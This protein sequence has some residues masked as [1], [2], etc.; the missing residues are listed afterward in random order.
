VPR[1]L[2]YSACLLIG[3]VVGVMGGF[4]QAQRWIFPLP[5][6]VIAVPWGALLVLLVLVLVI[7]GA[8]WTLGSRWAGA[9]L[10]IG[11]LAG[12]LGLAL[13]TPSGD[14]A[15]SG[16]GRQWGYVI[17]GAILGAAACSLP[18]LPALPIL[19]AIPRWPTRSTKGTDSVL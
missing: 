13:E 9:V 11:W 16:G 4:V 10:F 2:G 3:L 14:L 8:C 17:G 18:M 5:D 1:L 19:P 15:I 7:R 12:T 6:F